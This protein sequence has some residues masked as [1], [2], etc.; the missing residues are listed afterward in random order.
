[1]ECLPHPLKSPSPSKE[2]GKDIKKEAK[3][4]LNCRVCYF[5]I[6]Y[7]FIKIQEDVAL[8]LLGIS[9]HLEF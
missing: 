7:L 9:Q 8:L 3:P 4:L 1:M 5:R 2:R 6:T